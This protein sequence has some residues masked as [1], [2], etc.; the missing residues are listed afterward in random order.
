MQPIDNIGSRAMWTMSHP[1]ANDKMDV[2]GNPNF[3]DPT[4]TI[5]L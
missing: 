1:N 2:A 5:L 3:P 4:N